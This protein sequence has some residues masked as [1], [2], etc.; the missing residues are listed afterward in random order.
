MTWLPRAFL[1]A[2]TV[3][4]VANAPACKQEEKKDGGK[5]GG[6]EDAEGTRTRTSTQSRPNNEEEQTNTNTDPCRNSST[7]TK[8][9]TSSQDSGNSGEEDMGIGL[10][11]LADK[12]TYEGDV[13]G[14]LGKYC[15]SCHGAGGK[16]P[17]LS[18]YSAAKSAAQSAVDSIDAGDMPKGGGTVA[19]GDLTKLKQWITD[20]KPEKATTS[21]DTKT[22]TTSDDSDSDN[23]NDSDNSSSG[24]Q[25]SD[26][27]DKT[28]TSSSTDTETDGTDLDDA[29]QEL[30]NPPALKECHDQNKVYDRG[31][32]KCH[33]STIATSYECTPQ[34]IKDKFKKLA[35]TVN[36]SADGKTIAGFEGYDIDQCG[37][38]ENQ[39]VVFFYKKVEG[40]TDE[41][42]LEIKML[43]KK[44]SAACER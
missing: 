42:K 25:S 1:L 8:T 19:S 22:S 21:T 9:S 28:N 3:A 10:N 18:S 12:V 44:G 26:D 24:G 37:E 31:K 29:W 13:K 5:K 20:G 41:V 34:G 17:D 39:P 40:S 36:I 38:F 2:V 14:I 4:F 35:V 33:K 7:K 23:D 43:C 32:Q 15:T 27:C 16:S 11:L 30:L 6:D